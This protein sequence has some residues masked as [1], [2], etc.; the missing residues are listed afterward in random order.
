MTRMIPVNDQMIQIERK[1][2][3][4]KKAKNMNQVDILGVEAEAEAGSIIIKKKNIE[5]IEISKN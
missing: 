2:K 1:R 3:K 5:N 4:R